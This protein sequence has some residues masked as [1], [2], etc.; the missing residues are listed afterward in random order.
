LFFEQIFLF[1]NWSESSFDFGKAPLSV[2]KLS[3]A[4]HGL[5]HSGGLQ[6]HPSNWALHA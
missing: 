2:A 1:A 5:N 6:K 4:F 3:S